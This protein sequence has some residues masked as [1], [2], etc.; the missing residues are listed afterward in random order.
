MLSNERE[1]KG[2]RF[3]KSPC[4]LTLTHVCVCVCV[5]VCVCVMH[6][7]HRGV[8][9]ALWWGTDWKSERLADFLPKLEEY[10]VICLQEVFLI[11]NIRV[12]VPIVLVRSFDVACVLVGLVFVALVVLMGF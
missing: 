2:C 1:R 10:D 6:E 5:Y 8:W 7:P 4:I 11:Q 12:C 9:A 3:L